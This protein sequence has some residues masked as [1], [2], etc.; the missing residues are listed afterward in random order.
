MRLAPRRLI[1]DEQ[2]QVMVFVAI[3]MTGLVSVVGLVTDGGIVFSQRRDL[4]NVADAAALAG[5][6]QIDERAYRASGQVV[7]DDAKARDAAEQY[8]RDEEDVDYTVQVSQAGVEV[9]VSRRAS[10]SFLRL[11]GIDSV[12]ISATSSAAPRHGVAE[13]E[14]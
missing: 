7:L 13:A 4:Q 14:R 2:G 11:V 8:L 5:A 10:T 9:S 6:M 3:L 1:Q 12:D